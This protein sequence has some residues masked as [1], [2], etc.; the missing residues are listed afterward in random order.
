MYSA[1]LQKEHVNHMPSPRTSFVLPVR[2]GAATL[3]QAIHSICQQ[4]DSNFELLI[5]N[6]GST[7]H[8]VS[9][10]K[11]YQD[12][13]IRLL[14]NPGHGIVDALNYGIAEA[15]GTFIARMDA[16]DIARPHRLS[17]QLELLKNPT[18]G[19][20]DGQVEFFTDSGPVPEGMHHY[21]KWINQIIS[22]KDFD[23]ELLVESPIVHPAATFRRE[24]VQQLG[25]YRNG[26]FP[27]DYDLWLRM[28]AAGLLLQKVPETLV[29]MRDHSTRLT[30]TDSRYN[31]AGF[32]H[33]RQQWLANKLENKRKR[34][35]LFGAGKECSPWL[36]WL[37]MMGHEITAIFDVSPAR[38][39]RTK[40]DIPVLA[41]QDINTVECDLGLI[42]VSTRGVRG[43]LRSLIEEHRP[44]WREGVNW[45]AVR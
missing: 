15:R 22:P 3:D 27:E 21:A 25:G 37:R 6:D 42:L 12:N 24:V 29:R 18:L 13:R 32:R 9:V 14:H 38:I 33:V 36:R 41:L 19:V 8:S 20:V 39:G 16:D 34:F 1:P 2:N 4:D 10:A 17:V 23:R 45:W 31:R 43:Q 28:H 26:P 7:D 11:A 5:I 44:N 40:Q 30:R 35:I